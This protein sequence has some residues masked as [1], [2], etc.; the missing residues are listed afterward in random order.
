[1]KEHG[2]ITQLM[3]QADINGQT[4]VVIM[5]SGWWEKCM[6]KEDMNGMVFFFEI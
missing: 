1:M 6:V 4:D 5:E 2:K 3:V